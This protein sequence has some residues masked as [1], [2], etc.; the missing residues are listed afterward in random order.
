[1]QKVM[2]G[3]GTWGTSLAFEA[4]GR[5]WLEVGGLGVEGAVGGEW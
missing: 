1:M 3:F 5:G 4:G 2:H